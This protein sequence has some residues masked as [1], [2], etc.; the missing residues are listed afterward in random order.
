MGNGPLLEIRS[1]LLT[2]ESCRSRFRHSNY[3]WL[4]PFSTCSLGTTGRVARLA[5]FYDF[6]GLAG[7][8]RVTESRIAVRHHGN[9]RR[10]Q[11]IA[12]R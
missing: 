4:I 1:S 10:W 2:Q 12:R 11:L 3:R 8:D 5:D 6:Y 7:V 9:I